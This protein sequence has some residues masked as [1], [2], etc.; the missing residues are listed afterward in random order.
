MTMSKPAQKAVFSDVTMS[1][2]V[3]KGA[4]GLALLMLL[5]VN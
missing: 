4:R 5:I 3:S 1:V 2:K